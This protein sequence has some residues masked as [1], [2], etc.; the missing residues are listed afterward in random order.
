METNFAK[1]QRGYEIK[2]K[3]LAIDCEF[4]LK[5]ISWGGQFANLAKGGECRGPL[6][7]LERWPP[8]QRMVPMH[9][10]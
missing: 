1:A 6:V 10:H 3:N 9:L 5:I 8:I 2:K 7:G 4:R